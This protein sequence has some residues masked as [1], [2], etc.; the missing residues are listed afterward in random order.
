MRDGMQSSKTFIVGLLC[1]FA[2]QCMW[3]KAHGVPQTDAKALQDLS[4]SL[5]QSLTLR[6]P[7]LY[8]DLLRG[9]TEAQ[10]TLNQNPDIELMYID[11]RGRPVFYIAQNLNAAR[12]ISTDDVWPG[13]SAGF[14]LSGSGTGLGELC[15]W[16]AGGVLTTHQEFG[17]RV[18]Q[19]DAPGTTHYHSTHVAGT[20]VAAGVDAGAKGMSYQGTL[21]A[22]DWNS[23]DSEMAS[24]A[25]SGMNISNHSYGYATGW[26]SSGSWYWFGDTT[27]STTEDYGF[28]FYGSTARTWDSIACAAPYYTI[29]KSAG[30]DR[31]DYGPGPGGGHWV[32]DPGIGNWVWSTGT[33]DPDGGSDGYDC[34]PWNGTAKNIIT[35]GAVHD[36][37]GGYTC[38]GDVVMSDFSGWG[39]ADDGRIKPDLVANGISLHSCDDAGNS[40]YTDLSGTS[41][42]APNVSGS[43]N[44]LVRYYE[45]THGDST[46]LSSTV[47]ATVIQTADEAGANP[48]P[49][50][51]FGWGLMNTTKAAQLIEADSQGSAHII[52]ASLTNGETDQYCIYNGGSDPVRI[53]LVWTDPPGTPPSPSLNPTAPMLVNDLDLSLEHVPTSIVYYPYTLDPGNPG[54]S[55]SAGDNTRDNVEQVH[56][57]SP[58]SGAY[59]IS[60]SHKGVLAAAQHYSV[61]SSHPMRVGECNQR[62]VLTPIGPK[63]TSEG[64]TLRFTV[65]ANDPDGDSLI[66]SADSLPLNASFTDHGDGS[67]D[68]LFVPDSS[69]SG[70]H[71]VIFSAYD[72]EYADS[73]VVSI[74]VLVHA[75]GDCN[76]DGRITVADGTYLVAFIYRGGP[77]PYGEADVNLDGRLT[78]ADA[79]Y[80]V[81]FLYRHGPP[82]CEPP[83]GK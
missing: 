32:W 18:T 52:E 26:Y 3:S 77:P 2:G 29:V 80:I 79:M 55:A 74:R 68:F 40:S 34:I 82:P 81:T 19:M 16:D 30:N 41:M 15:V 66:L 31:N 59:Q 51:E 42:S 58:A 28:G 8:Y 17:S 65:T 45:A 75:C 78:I 6:R 14:S 71:E 48:G 73:E 21:A 63:L 76:G 25:A 39:P 70:V 24:A 60:V 33:R 11:E 4:R 46:P 22:Y 36:I 13:G 83:L 64:D 10:R 53:T 69:Q 54:N 7:Q 43:L 72:G 47:K 5:A 61:V 23:D 38:P 12:T 27:I 20:M 44:L 62:P 1:L 37:P 9:D 67:A 57:S 56:V 35:V 50:Y 49:D